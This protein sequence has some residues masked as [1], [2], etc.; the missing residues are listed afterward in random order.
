MNKQEMMSI[1]Y[2]Q[3]AID[4]NCK[5]EDFNKDGVI[6]TIAEKQTG[7]RE[8]PFVHHDSKSLQWA[9]VRLLMYR[10]I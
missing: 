4:Y 10:K 3:L 2:N 8:M 6:F 9:K 7:R 1:V 5:P